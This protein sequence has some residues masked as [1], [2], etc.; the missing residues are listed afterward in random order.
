MHPHPPGR[1]AGRAR[2]RGGRR[3]RWWSRPVRLGARRRPPTPRGTGR[4]L[5]GRWR[6]RRRNAAARRAARRRVRGG[7]A[8]VGSTE[9]TARLV[10]R[11]GPAA[12]RTRTAAFAAAAAAAA[13]AG[14]ALARD[15]PAFSPAG[16]WPV[17]EA[18]SL[19]AG[20]LLI[21]AALLARGPLRGG[22]GLLV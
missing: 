12:A 21:V 3:R 17:A 1:G 14:L 6:G 9:V 5:V 7:P 11:S 19:A 15:E 4:P 2:A 10:L 20:A 22:T 18:A 16:P 8:R 13:V